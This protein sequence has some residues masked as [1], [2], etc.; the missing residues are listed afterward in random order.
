MN[1]AQADRIIN[2]ALGLAAG[3]R[4]DTPLLRA[5]QFVR[6]QRDELEQDAQ[7]WC[8]RFEWLR[9]NIEGAHLTVDEIDAA[10]A[11]SRP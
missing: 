8:D 5:A 4:E 1:S 10:L 3:P 9:A 6:S 7:Q 11:R 2:K